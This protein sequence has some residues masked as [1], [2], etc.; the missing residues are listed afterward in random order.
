MSEVD[1]AFKPDSIRELIKESAVQGRA[2]ANEGCADEQVK[3]VVFTL[4][5]S[6]LAFRGIDVREILVPGKITEV[7][8]LPDFVLGILNV[9]GDVESLVDIRGLLG[10]PA[11]AK[12]WASRVLIIEK[13][14]LRTGIL[15]DSVEDVGDVAAASI[16]PA[17]PSLSPAIAELVAGEIMRGHTSVTLL[18]LEQL[19]ARLLSSLRAA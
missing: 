14:G 19:A 10:L 1:R 8:G 2:A 13:G 11:A 17:L 12:T 7:P 16:R 15:V 18:D 9:R 3:V 5:G 4:S 6:W